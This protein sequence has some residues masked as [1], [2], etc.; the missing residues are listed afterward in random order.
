MYE[1]DI[2]WKSCVKVGVLV[3]LYIFGLLINTC[4][5]HSIISVLWVSDHFGLSCKFSF[6]VFFSF[7]LITFDDNTV[8]YFVGF[9]SEFERPLETTIKNTLYNGSSATCNKICLTKKNKNGF[10][11]TYY[12]TIVLRSLFSVII[13]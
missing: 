11:Q 3:N 10:C 4:F 1:K 13:L 7:I 6:I 5:T 12:T 8:F 2:I 9:K